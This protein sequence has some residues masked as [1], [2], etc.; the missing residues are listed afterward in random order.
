MFFNIVRNIKYSHPTYSKNVEKKSLTFY[1][2][3]F[4]QY[5]TEPNLIQK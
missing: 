5:N 4:A 3:E 1:F 2:C